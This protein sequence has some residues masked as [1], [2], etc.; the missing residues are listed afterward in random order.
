[1]EHVL[2]VGANVGIGYY[3]AKQLIEDG[4]RVSVLDINIDNIGR[5]KEN[6]PDSLFTV[7]ADATNDT[8]IAGGVSA[9]IAHFGMIDA[10]I[11]NACICTFDGVLETQ[12]DVYE[13]VMDVNYYGALRLAKTVLP[14]M[15]KAKKGRLIF[16]SSGVGVTGFGN[17]SPYASSKGAIEAF[18]KCL[19]VENEEF[20]ISVHLF[21][22]PLTNTESARALPV[23][24]EF[25]ADPEKVGR[26]L[27]KKVFSKKFVICHSFSQSLQMKLCYFR[28]LSTGK[29]MWKMIQ[30]AQLP[31]SAK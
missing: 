22:P 15:Q 26:G 10:A 9:A 5:L 13:K 16:T 19:A 4:K 1:M 11:H 23:P 21:H 14:Y 28:P 17:I 24:K 25:K 8:S 7:H 6:Y 29:M 27:G 2:I 31:N 30:R 18:A 12:M 20:G 3:I